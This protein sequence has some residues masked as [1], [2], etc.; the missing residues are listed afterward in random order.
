[1]QANSM[2]RPCAYPKCS[3]HVHTL[4]DCCCRQ[5]LGDACM[6]AG[7]FFMQHYSHVHMFSLADQLIMW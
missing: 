7:H 3:A 4:A 5:L 2:L 1:M 6:L